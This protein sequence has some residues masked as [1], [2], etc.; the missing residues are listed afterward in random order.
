MRPQ[1]QVNKFV[2]EQSSMGP[3]G[4]IEC[5]AVVRP[6]HTGRLIGRSVRTDRWLDMGSL[7]PKKDSPVVIVSDGSSPT[8]TS[9]LVP[10][11]AV[12][13]DALPAVGFVYKAVT[14]PKLK[15]SNMLGN[16]LIPCCPIPSNMY[17]VSTTSIKRS[18]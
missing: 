15:D 1:V 13:K 10:A 18:L 16:I 7:V 12:A 4:K 11:P 14:L 8:G 6:K 9:Y 5:V 17:L 2:D 3:P